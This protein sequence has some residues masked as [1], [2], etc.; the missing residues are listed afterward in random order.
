MI[1]LHDVTPYSRLPHDVILAIEAIAT[2][3]TFA[4]GNHMFSACYKE[5][6][7]CYAFLY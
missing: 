3:T 2:R 4:K 5:K 6:I 1:H 7:S